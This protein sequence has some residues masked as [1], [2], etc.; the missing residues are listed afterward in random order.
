MELNLMAFSPGPVFTNRMQCNT[1]GGSWRVIYMSMLYLKEALP[2]LAPQFFSCKTGR[3]QLSYITRSINKALAH[4]F[5]G[6]IPTHFNLETSTDNVLIHV[7][8]LPIR[9]SSSY[10]IIV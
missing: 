7:A 1:F 10:V 2:C 4:N 3:H 9:V 5:P 6:V 8:A